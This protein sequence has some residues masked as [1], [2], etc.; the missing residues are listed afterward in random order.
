MATDFFPQRPNAHP[1][2]YAYEDTNPQYQGLL[3]VGYAAI[4]VDKRV[5]QQYPT[6][7]PDG[8]VP[9]RIVFRESAMYSDGSSF[10]DHD[11][12]RILK[13]K[14]IAGMGGEWFRCT[15][16]DV[17]AAVLAVKNHTANAENRVNSFSMRPEQQEAVDKPP[18]IFRVLMRRTLHATPS[19]CGTAKCDSAKP[20]HLI[21]WQN[22]WGSRRF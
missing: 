19:F 14:Q 16:D 18:L 17:R 10:T 1:M 22:E 20:L 11:V 15:V 5:A 4:D 21:S 8:S 13:R 2:I 3:K 7:R 12:H 9:Y 6:K